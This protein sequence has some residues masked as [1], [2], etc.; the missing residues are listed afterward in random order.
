MMMCEALG[1]DENYLVDI[2][3]LDASQGLGA[4]GGTADLQ[5]QS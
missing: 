3:D 4:F 2:V 5:Q 1:S